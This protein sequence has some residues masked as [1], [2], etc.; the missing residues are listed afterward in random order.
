[1]INLSGEDYATFI[2][3]SIGAL[4]SVLFA[5]YPKKTPV[6]SKRIMLGSAIF[7]NII[8]SAMTAEYLFNEKKWIF[9]ILPAINFFHAAISLV[10]SD[11]RLINIYFPDTQSRTVQVMTGIIAILLIAGFCKVN[12]FDWK[13]SYS[14]CI[15]FS[16]LF[17]DVI[18]EPIE[19]ILFRKSL[20]KK[21]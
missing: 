18:V 8:I 9:M 20:Q 19:K 16:Q 2:I 12:G 14:L 11:E 5:F 17:L 1:M 7:M 15:M 10:I 4:F 3:I 21:V 6:F 13:I